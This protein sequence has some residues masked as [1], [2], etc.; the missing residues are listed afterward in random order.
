M[1]A[2]AVSE[3][4]GEEE[5]WQGECV[6]MCACACMRI[7]A[8]M[9]MRAWAATHQRLEVLRQLLAAGVA[10]VHRDEVANFL[11]EVDHLAVGELEALFVGLYGVEDATHLLRN[12]REHLEIDAV[13]L[14]EAAPH[15]GLGEALDDLASRAVVH[16]VAATARV[17]FERARFGPETQRKK[18]EARGKGRELESC[19]RTS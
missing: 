8:C 4:R 15:A 6:R 1:R 7:R 5:A 18:L 13:E 19:V 16:L 12:D 3:Y 10:G 9:R 11:V 17:G 2:R 14:V